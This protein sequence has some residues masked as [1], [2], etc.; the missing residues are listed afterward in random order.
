MLYFSSGYYFTDGSIDE[1]RIYDMGLSA[2]EIMNRYNQT[3]A[4]YGL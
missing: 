3:K 1:L 4:R 2:T